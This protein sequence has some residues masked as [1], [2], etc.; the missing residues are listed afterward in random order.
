M[1]RLIVRLA[2]FVR[3]HQPLPAVPY[4][5]QHLKRQR[6]IERNQQTAGYPKR[7]TSSTEGS[8]TTTGS[9]IPSRCPRFVCVKTITASSS[10]SCTW[11]RVSVE[12]SP[13]RER[14]L[15][16]RMLPPAIL[17]NPA[18]RI[19]PQKATSVSGSKGSAR[20]GHSR[21]SYG[22]QNDHEGMRER[23]RHGT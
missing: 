20:V 4:S 19:L 5:T 6:I 18:R 21:R 10:P 13:A 12:S 8:R 11:L 22:E 3:P 9:S 14:T 2:A 7:S 17:T 15:E 16:P 23:L 1:S